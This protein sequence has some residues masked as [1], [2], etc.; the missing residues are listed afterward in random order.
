PPPSAPTG[1]TRAETGSG[2]ATARQPRLRIAV[3]GLPARR[4]L[5]ARPLLPPVRAFAPHCTIRT[6]HSA[7]RNRGGGSLLRPG[8]P[9]LYSRRASGGPPAAGARFCPPTLRG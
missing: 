6:P 8:A 9:L 5:P 7:I 3:G 4:R 2:S 1:R